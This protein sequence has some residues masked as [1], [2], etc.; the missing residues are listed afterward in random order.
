VRGPDRPLAVAGRGL[1]CVF[2]SFVE[3]S[4]TDRTLVCVVVS[5]LF[6]FRTRFDRA[7]RGNRRTNLDPRAADP[8]SLAYLTKWAGEIEDGDVTS[9]FFLAY[10]TL[11][12][13]PYLVLGAQESCPC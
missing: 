3:K 13:V 4:H 10:P 8:I 7:F 2:L 5:R 11:I 9:A 12:H 6:D 1:T